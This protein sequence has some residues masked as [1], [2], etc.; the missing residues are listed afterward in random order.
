M[1]TSFLSRSSIAK[2]LYEYYSVFSAFV[3]LFYFNLWNVDHPY[4]YLF[5]IA[6]IAVIGGNL[7]NRKFP[8]D[9]S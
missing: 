9:I 4:I 6:P 8:L 2:I 3:I 7:L 1:N 5:I